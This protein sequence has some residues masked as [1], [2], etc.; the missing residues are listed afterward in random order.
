MEEVLGAVV[1]RHHLVLEEATKSSW[2]YRKGKQAKGDLE[3][4]SL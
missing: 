1:I 3:Y 2:K 4:K